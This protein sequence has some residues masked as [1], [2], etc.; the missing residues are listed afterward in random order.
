MCIEIKIAILLR[1]RDVSCVFKSSALRFGS[2]DLRFIFLFSLCSKILAV[3]LITRFRFFFALF[4][5]RCIQWKFNLILHSIWLRAFFISFASFYFFVL[6]LF[7]FYLR[8]SSHFVECNSIW[9]KTHLLDSSDL[10][11]VAYSYGI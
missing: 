7:F 3:I 11:T 1:F 4:A 2:N 8:F 6:L 10:Y 9:I 5:L